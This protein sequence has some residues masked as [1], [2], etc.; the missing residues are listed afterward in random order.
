MED[1]A[2]VVEV[3]ADEQTFLEHHL[4]V[5]SEDRDS[6]VVECYRRRPFAVFGSPIATLLRTWVIVCTTRSRP[7]SRSMSLHRTPSASPR[8]MPVVAST[9]T[10]VQPIVRFA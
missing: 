4:A 5:R 9:P 3:G 10:A 6:A 2:R 1:Q 7:A 8:R